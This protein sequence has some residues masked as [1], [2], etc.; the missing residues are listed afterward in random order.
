MQR[1]LAEPRCQADADCL[2][3]AHFRW[4]N[5]CR[6]GRH[7]PE[8]RPL[9][10]PRSGWFS[11]A[12]AEAWPE[13]SDREVADSPQQVAWADEVGFAERQHRE[14]GNDTANDGQ[15]ATGCDGS[16][17]C[18]GTLLFQ[19][20]QMVQVQ[21]NL[22]Q[23]V[24][25][26]H[27]YN[28]ATGILPPPAITDAKGKALLSW[29]VAI[30][31]YI[32]QSTLYSQFKLNEPWDSPNNK[33]LLEKMPR[34]YAPVGIKT[35]LPHSTYYQLCTGPNTPWP[36]IS[37]QARIPATFQDGTSNTF[38]IVEAS[39][40]VEWTRPVDLAIDPKKP[41]PGLG[42]QIKEKFLVGMGDGSVAV[43]PRDA[44]PKILR[45]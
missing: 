16:Q 10:E 23:L 5:R 41:L 34:I 15:S 26:M 28:D 4:K 14:E 42:A 20:G 36:T 31:P 30:L 1:G 37:T 17:D 3:Q 7:G 6:G 33:K 40:P 21:N 29:R 25:A 9:R 13:S 11:H 18:I 45:C 44:D 32:E 27:N 35:K 2:H 22:K 19:V 12:G 38:L 39:T 24:L 43:L 8:D